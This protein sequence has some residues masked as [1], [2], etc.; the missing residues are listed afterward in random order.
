MKAA[1]KSAITLK[2]NLPDVFDEFSLATME[3]DKELELMNLPE[4]N[5]QERYKKITLDDNEDIINRST[6]IP[7][8][9]NYEMDQLGDQGLSLM[10]DIEERQLLETTAKGSTQKAAHLSKIKKVIERV[11]LYFFK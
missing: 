6:M 2:E 10:F 5:V 9:Y 11:S 8:D 3:L 1:D 7:I 4:I